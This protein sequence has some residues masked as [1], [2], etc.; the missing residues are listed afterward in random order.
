ERHGGRVVGRI[1]TFRDPRLAQA[2][3]AAG[4]HDQVVQAPDGRPY[5]EPAEFTNFAHPAVR[6]YNLDIAY[7]ATSHG[8]NDILWDDVRQ[9]GGDPDEVVVPR[10]TGTAADSIVSFLA[11]AHAQLRRR[12]AYQGVTVEGAAA[13]RGAPS[14]QD[15]PRIARNAD[16]VAPI[17]FP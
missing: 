1:S 10:L 14:G 7:E 5:G 6:R 4:Q 8:V 3:W 16:Y 15:V 12:G 11:E 17:I 9:P 2:A 13:D